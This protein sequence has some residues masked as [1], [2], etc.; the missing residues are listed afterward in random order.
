[1]KYVKSQLNLN[2][3]P[4]TRDEIINVDYSSNLSHITY[5]WEQKMISVEEY[6]HLKNKYNLDE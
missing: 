5:M 4:M 6:K 2:K 3:N 1:M